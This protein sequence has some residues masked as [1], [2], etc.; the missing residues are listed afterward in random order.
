V[1]FAHIVGVDKAK[2]ELT[3]AVD[4]PGGR[5]NRS[6]LGAR[7]LNGLLLVG[8]YQPPLMSTGSGKPSG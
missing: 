2:D 8:S 1:T 3:V 4:L 6:R 5:S 7:L